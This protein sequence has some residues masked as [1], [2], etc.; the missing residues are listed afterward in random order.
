MVPLPL[1]LF[2]AECRIEESEIRFQ[3]AYRS[4]EFVMLVKPEGKPL[5]QALEGKAECRLP[6]QV[7]LGGDLGGQNLPRLIVAQDFGNQ[8]LALRFR[9]GK[10][11][12]DPHDRGARI[13][14]PVGPGAQS[15]VKPV[16]IGRHCGRRRAEYQ[17]EQGSEFAERAVAGFASWAPAEFHPQLTPHA[18]SWRTVASIATSTPKR[19]ATPGTADCSGRSTFRGSEREVPA[20][21]RITLKILL[22]CPAL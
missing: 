1:P 10:L 18:M 21:N 12:A 11:S 19:Q 13:V 6:F 8:R 22:N 14:R 17:P 16:Q 15:R 3:T 2:G 20:T 4:A 9:G 7:R 5:L